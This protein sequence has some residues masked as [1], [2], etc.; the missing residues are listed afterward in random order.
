MEEDQSDISI[1]NF[2]AMGLY[3]EVMGVVRILKQSLKILFRNGSLTACTTLVTLFPNSL[4]FFSNI[5][6]IKLLVFDLFT[7]SHLLRTS[8][9]FALDLY[10]LF[11]C[12]N[13]DIQ[14]LSAVKLIFFIAY[15]LVTL[16]SILALLISSTVFH[17]SKN[18][19][20][21]E[22]RWS[23]GRT[24]AMPLITWV[25]ITLMGV[26]YTL[27][28][29]GL[30][31]L[32]M[33]VTDSLAATFF[34]CGVLAILSISLFL[35]SAVVWM[36]GLVIFVVEERCYIF[37]TLQRSE[38]V[39]KGGTLHGLVLSLLYMAIG[40]GLLIAF[41]LHRV[42]Q[43]VIALFIVG[44]VIVNVMCL[45]KIISLMAYMVF[46]YECQKSNGEELEL[47]IQFEYISL[48]DVFV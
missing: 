20:P 14:A 36:S 46:Y 43:T 40:F 11:E 18:F 24:W 29:V 5:I 32:L 23:I 6:S 12:I 44:L 19:E 16:F 33:L 7:R 15:S 1:D 41:Q 3:S 8:D 37:E 35:Y 42:N 26:G 48:I 28:L 21:K 31:G 34:A 4:L 30:I 22:L 47:P 17:S 9:P 25:Y 10:E 39:T 2:S 38:E 13:E 27:L 45:M